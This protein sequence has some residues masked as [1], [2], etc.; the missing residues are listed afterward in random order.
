MRI[1]YTRQVKERVL[2]SL[3]HTARPEAVGQFPERVLPGPTEWGGMR[4][5]FW[6]GSR[7]ASFAATDLETLLNGSEAADVR[8]SCRLLY[9]YG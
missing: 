8:S 5:R 3:Q 7:N 1:L 4:W 6:T 2:C 9:A